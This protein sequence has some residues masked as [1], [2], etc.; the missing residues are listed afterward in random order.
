MIKYLLI[1]AAFLFIPPAYSQET[2][3][4]TTYYPAPFGVYGNLRLFPTDAEPTCATSND[5]GVFY[6]DLSQHT[7]RACKFNT[8]NNRYEFQD[9]G[10]G[11]WTLN[12]T[13][14]YPNDNDW[15]VGI[16]TDTPHAKLD[17]AGEIKTGNTNLAC[18]AST[19]GA[20][21]Y[22]AAERTV[23]VCNLVTGHPVWHNLITRCRVCAQLR[24]WS[25]DGDWTCSAYSVNGTQEETGWASDSD[26]YDPDKVRI[27]IQCD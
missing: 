19:L 13:S 4:I 14:L 11:F 20:I 25:T 10:G 26:G 18:N 9:M 8:G 27:R 17:V 21:R 2:L 22:N 6:Y 23:Q 3:T 12:G 7:Y 16:A 5:E 24:D 1:L 15:N